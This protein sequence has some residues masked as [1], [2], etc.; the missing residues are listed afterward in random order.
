MFNQFSPG[1]MGKAGLLCLLLLN[2]TSWKRAFA[3]APDERPIKVISVG[4]PKI[5]YDTA[6]DG[7]NKLDTPD[8][9]ARAIRDSKGQIH[10]FF[11]VSIDHEK[12]REM[13]GPDFAHLRPS[14]DVAY[15]GAVN[16]DPAAYNDNQWL[17]SFFVENHTVFALVH[18]E[19]HAN[20]N[21]ALCPSGSP[22]CNE[23]SISQ[24]YSKDD[25]FHF[26]AYPAGKGFVAAFPF[27]YQIPKHFFGISGPT[28]ILK[29]GGFYYT[30][31]AQIHP[32]DQS[33]NGICVLRTANIADPSSWRGWNGHDFSITFVNP[34]H[35]NVAYEAKHICIP[36]ENKALFNTSCLSWMPSRQSF[37]AVTR[38]Q[39]WDKSRPDLIDDTPGVYISESRDMINWSRP[40]L[41]LSDA[42]AGG[43]EQ[44]YPS[45]IDPNSNDASFTTLGP[46]PILFTVT[47]IKGAGYGSCKMNAR[48][49]KLGF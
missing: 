35:V 27:R 42:D 44:R 33:L 1:K 41:L 16:K 39:R 32:T 6:R 20:E 36:L 2:V 23:E 17:S 40:S 14:Y 34:Y 25:G 24:V 48:T 15:Q 3:E 7:C 22:D 29:H 10:L 18:N 12:N 49:L 9:A 26:T 37:L 46:N 28:N 31:V 8:S 30:M 38:R 45:L 13:I 4:K 43:L 19:W 47:S 11:R 5:I 21:R